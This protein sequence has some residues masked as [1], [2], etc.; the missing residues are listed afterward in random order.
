M[1]LL[2]LFDPGFFEIGGVLCIARTAGTD[3]ET[4]L[5]EIDRRAEKLKHS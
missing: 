2:G 5:K 1:R 4:E 3:Y